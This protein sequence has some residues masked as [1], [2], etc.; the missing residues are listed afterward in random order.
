MTNYSAWTCPWMPIVCIDNGQEYIGDQLMHCCRKAVCNMICQSLQIIACFLSALRSCF[1]TRLQASL[2]IDLQ[3]PH[4]VQCRLEVAVY[5]YTNVKNKVDNSTV[6]L[7]LNINS[8]NR[9]AAEQMA[10]WWLS[11]C[12]FWPQSYF[13]TFQC[14][15]AFY[16]QATKQPCC[17]NTR[18]DF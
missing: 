18:G 14:Y 16:H 15:F 10:F 6:L 13:T 4:H 8:I 2:C 11:P 7:G 17:K 1:V 3:K 9:S 5:M 12:L